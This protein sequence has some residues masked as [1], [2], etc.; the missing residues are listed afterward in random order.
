MY[1]DIKTKNATVDYVKLSEMRGFLTIWIGLKYDG[2]CQGFGGHVL[3]YLMKD[4]LSDRTG[5]LEHWVVSLM[6]LFGVE[7]F[8][9]I[10]GKPC[11]VKASNNK[12]HAIGNFLEDKW[13]HAVLKEESQ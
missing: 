12:V 2:G 9:D 11:R 13:F 6:N 1:D 4:K 10:K 5:Y 7:D 3:G 8:Y